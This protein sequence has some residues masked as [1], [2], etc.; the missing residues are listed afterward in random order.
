[1]GWRETCST[2]M[3]DGKGSKRAPVALPALRGRNGEIKLANLT[4]GTQAAMAEGSET[5]KEPSDWVMS[6]KA[7]LK[8]S[9]ELETDSDDE[10][11]P[12]NSDDDSEYEERMEKKEETRR[13]SRNPLIATVAAILNERCP[14]L[15]VGN[16]QATVAAETLIE[17]GAGSRRRASLSL[18]LTRSRLS[19]I[20]TRGGR[21]NDPRETRQTVARSLRERRGDLPRGP[22]LHRM[23]RRPTP[24]RSELATWTQ[25]VRPIRARGEPRAF[26][27]DGRSPGSSTRWT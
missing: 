1:M 15:I 26:P 22:C 14:A 25:R 5:R 23:P 17:R 6:L 16:T 19:Q 8:D 11:S 10:S 24:L 9:L 2:A 12:E 3:M 20:S 18:P 21:P 13:E 27:P 7:A 4:A